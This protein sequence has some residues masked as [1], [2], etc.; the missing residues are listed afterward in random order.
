MNYFVTFW[1][2]LIISIAIHELGHLIVALLCGIKVEAFSL[3]FGK[4]LSKKTIKGIE[5]RW[6]AIPLG[7]YCKLYGE[8]TTEVGGWLSQRYLKKFLVLIAGVA[9][10]FIAACLCYYINYKSIRLGVKI[11]LLFYKFVLLKDDIGQL[12][13]LLLSDTNWLL[14]QFSLIN[15]GSAILNILPFPALDGGHIVF[16]WLEKIWKNKFVKYYAVL[17]T[18]GFKLLILLQIAIVVF[19]WVL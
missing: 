13:L 7:G 4:I 12:Q 10:N 17:N 2:L 1:I 11:D 9:F 19:Y 5:F 15:L 16:L 14:L 6:S 3:G 18:I 8:D